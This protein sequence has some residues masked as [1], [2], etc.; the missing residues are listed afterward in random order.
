MIGKKF[1]VPR[2]KYLILISLIISKQEHW[3][4]IDTTIFGKIGIVF[5]ILAMV[6]LIIGT[7]KFTERFLLVR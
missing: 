3:I 1:K 7:K 2:L 5:N 4:I 6:G